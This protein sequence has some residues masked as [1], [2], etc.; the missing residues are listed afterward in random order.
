[1]AV[2][3]NTTSNLR[4][5]LDLVR[6]LSDG[7][8]TPAALEMQ[9]AVERYRRG[10]RL[11][12][13]TDEPRFE[14]LLTVP[15]ATLLDL[16]LIRFLEALEALLEHARSGAALPEGAEPPSAGLEASADPTVGLRLLGGADPCLVEVGVDLLSILEPVGGMEGARGNDLALF[17]F[18]ANLRALLAFCD[19]LLREFAAFP[20][21]PSAVAKGSAS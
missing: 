12:K 4:F 5:R 13:G 6:R 18:F 10:D 3:L 17:R 16:D 1:V 14:P 15:R 20:T 8:N 21:D 7:V 11:A 19:G 2:L 9:V